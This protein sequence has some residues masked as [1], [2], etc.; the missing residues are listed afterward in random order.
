M[1]KLYTKCKVITLAT[2]LPVMED[3]HTESL[4]LGVSSQICLKSKRVDCWNE[5]FDGIQRGAWDGCV[6]CH[7]TSAKRE[8]WCKFFMLLADVKYF[9]FQENVCW[10]VI[11][12]AL[13]SEEAHQTS[14]SETEA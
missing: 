6:L 9:L 14:S 8:K 11:Y 1:K 7:V 12:K 3:R 4:S 13:N 5:S 10:I 2:N